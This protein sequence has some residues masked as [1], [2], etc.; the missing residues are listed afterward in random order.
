ML[1]QPELLPSVYEFKGS[2][3]IANRAGGNQ[4]QQRMCLTNMQ[5]AHAFK[6]TRGMS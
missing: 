2:S 5:K 3:E 6:G 1:K 4:N